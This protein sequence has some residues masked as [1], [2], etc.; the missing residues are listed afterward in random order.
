MI[1][2]IL[3]ILAL[4]YFLM[5]NNDLATVNLLYK[6]TDQI[7]VANVMLI[8]FG[9]GVIVGFLVATMSILSAKNTSRQLR[10]KNKKL[11]DE[12]NRLRNV[13]IDEETLPAE[14]QTEE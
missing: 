11:T 1:V 10:S 12:L 8:T 13:N 2:L 5:N 4:V 9:I 3:V 7:P 14:T 6:Q